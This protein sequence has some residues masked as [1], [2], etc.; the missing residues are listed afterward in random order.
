MFL[1][2]FSFQSFSSAYTFHGCALAPN[3]N[4][5]WVVTSDTALTFHSSDGGINWVE[6]FIP[7]RR[8]FY[9]VFFIDS[10]SGW[11]ASEIAII[12]YTSDGGLNW[13]WQSLGLSHYAT[14]V[15]FLDSLYGWAA[16]WDGI[17]IRTTDGGDEWLQVIIYWLPID[18]VDFYG[19][20]FIDNLKGWMCAGRY[21]EINYIG[22]TIFKKGQGF[23]V[24]SE[25]GG[26]S[27]VLQKRDTIYDFF[28]VKFKD[29][30][31]G[32]V[33]G[34]NDS[35][36]EAC[37]FHTLDGGLSWNLRTLPQG[38]KI[39]HSLELIDDNKLWA[40]GRNGT[41][42]HSSDGGNSWITQ[43]SGIDTTLYD[44][45][46]A[47]SLRG[48]IAG[49]GVVLYT[50]D[51]GNTW[52]QANVVGMES[53]TIRRPDFQITAYPNPFS[54]KIAIRFM[55]NVLSNELKIYDV[56]GKFVNSFS[57]NPQSLIPD[58]CFVWDGC[59]NAGNEVRPGVYFAIFDKF[60]FNSDNSYKQ[61]LQLVKV[62]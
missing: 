22:D 46:F 6:Q 34:G 60:G 56:T 30:L 44:V 10:L 36:M 28:D 9:D 37:V 11:I 27:W 42:I 13:H 29:S 35:T 57:T 1:L 4:Q 39:L 62:K 38:S 51:G 18:T 49:D 48:L 32:W 45:D 53:P 58:H 3:S 16:N 24:H 20:S 21:P 23:I 8:E 47:D 5:G 61:K 54:K 15:F 59:D 17:V 26:D 52:F 33:V 43:I 55:P 2:L 41:I 50:Q 14:R 19:V 25:N 31:E 12:W 40:V 7:T